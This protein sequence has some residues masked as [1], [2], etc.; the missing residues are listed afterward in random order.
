[1][2]EVT[3][4]DFP[5]DAWGRIREAV[6]PV[7]SEMADII[8]HYTAD[9]SWQPFVERDNPAGLAADARD[10]LGRLEGAVKDAKRDLARI[11]GAARLNAARKARQTGAARSRPLAL[12]PDLGEQPGGGR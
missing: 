4:D 6:H 8:H 2:A 12:A 7:I 5:A 11:E 10:L 1:M 3:S 9:G